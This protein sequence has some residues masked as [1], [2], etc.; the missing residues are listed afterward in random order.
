MPATQGRLYYGWVMVAGVLTVGAVIVGMGGINA[1]QF[2]RPVSEELGI[3]QTWF[4]WA[5]SARLLAFAASSWVIGRIVDRHGA[6]VPLACAG[7]VA[8]L[9]LFGLSNISQG[10]HIVVLYFLLGLTGLQGAGGNLYGSVALSRWFVRRRARA[11][12]IAF[13]GTPVGIFLFAPLTQFL[14]DHLGWRDAYL[15]LGI[16]GAVVIVTVSLVVLR[17][18]PEDL[19]LEPDGGSGPLAA[20]GSPPPRSAEYSWTRREAI[21]TATFKRLALVDGL[22]MVAIATLG[23]FRI[24]HYIEQGVDPS[25]VAL[26]LSAEAIASVAIALPAGWLLD[27]YPPRY[28]SAVATTIMIGT[29]FVTIGADSTPEVF[30]ATCMYGFGAASF[31][32]AQQSIWPHYFGSRHVG[33]IRGVSLFV[34]VSASA[35]GAPAAGWVRDTTGS[36]LPAWIVAMCALAVAAFVVATLPDPK[37]APTQEAAAVTAPSA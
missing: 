27:R 1:G 34:G 32:V 9:A 14:I 18:S 7:L 26:A 2:I 15:V 33:Q 13:L 20:D 6:R 11:L 19:G 3:G 5:Q 35:L 4:G 23:V 16:G 25:I 29:F 21:R 28:I 22:R 30:L 10:W 37:R 31:S 36:F 12:S 17:R 8:G 24:P